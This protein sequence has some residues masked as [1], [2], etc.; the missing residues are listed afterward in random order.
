MFN[1]DG[2]ES[3]SSV[4]A[5]APN[6]VIPFVVGAYRLSGQHIFKADLLLGLLRSLCTNKIQ[7]LF[8]ESM[9]TFEYVGQELLLWLHPQPDAY[10]HANVCSQGGEQNH[11]DLKGNYI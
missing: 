3:C 11:C 5:A 8:T 4:F 2:I 1:H 9:I 7:L 6:R 10:I